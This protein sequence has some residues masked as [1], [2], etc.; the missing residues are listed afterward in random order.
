MYAYLYGRLVVLGVDVLGHSQLA[1]SPKIPE[2]GIPLPQ[3]PRYYEQYAI[4]MMEKET[5]F[6]GKDI[7]NLS[8]GA[9]GRGDVVFQ[10][11]LIQYRGE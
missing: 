2:W 11:R 3:Y 6:A 8:K 10:D 5:G 7:F 9:G 4:R 1:G